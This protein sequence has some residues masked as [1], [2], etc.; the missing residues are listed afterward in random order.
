MIDNEIR[1]AL[2]KHMQPRRTPSPTR[3]TTH[4]LFYKN[5]MNTGWKMDEKVLRKIIQNNCVPTSSEDKLKLNIY[6]RTPTTAGMIMANNS[7]RD[8][9]KLKQ[10]NVV[11]FYKCNKG[12]CALLPKSGYVGL[13]TT[14]LSRRIT[15]HLQNGGPRTHTE[16]YHDTPLTRKDMTENTKILAVTSDKRRLTVLEAVFIR[17]LGPPINLQENARGTLQLYD[18]PLLKGSVPPSNEFP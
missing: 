17:E 10:A 11:Y 16:R 1:I 3:G 4:N 14:S 12:D 2:E 7:T 13:T 15:M 9:S 5:N 6:Y 18:G 8:H